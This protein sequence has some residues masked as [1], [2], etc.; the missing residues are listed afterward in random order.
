LLVTDLVF[1]GDRCCDHSPSSGYDQICSLFPE[2]GWL[3]GRALEEGRIVWHREPASFSERGLNVFHVI[4]GDCSG[5]P[6][7]RLLRERFPAALIVSSAH[8]PI[9]RL[10]GDEV[11]LAALKESDAI[12]TVCEEQRREIAELALQAPVYAVPH[13]V[14]TDVFR[15]TSASN[16]VQRTNVLFVGSFLRDWEEAKQV[17]AELAR[18]GVRPIALGAGP[19]QHLVGDELSIEVAPRVSEEEL[20]RMYHHAPAVFLPFLEATA[21]NALLEAMAAGCPVVCRRLP[22]LVDEYLGDESSSY[23]AGRFD[24][25][26][27]R[28]LYYVNNPSA[29]EAKSRELLARAAQFDWSRL[30]DRCAAVYDEVV[31]MSATAAAR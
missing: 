6:L 31:A 26:A 10:A 23:E 16:G 25:A 5:K 18:A 13:G 24:V 2:A 20:A 14:W 17:A 8:Q 22:S 29:R 11:A 19:R 27:A 21:S 4:Y 1:V 30:R 15:P 3:S 12:I 28:L 9:R 7:P